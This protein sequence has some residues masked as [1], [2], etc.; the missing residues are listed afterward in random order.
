[1][2]RSL[3]Q[4]KVDLILTDP[5]YGISRKTTFKNMGENGVKRLGVSMDFGQWDHA[6]INLRLFCEKS[7]SA[8]RK[9]G[10]IIVFHDL[11]HSNEGDLIVDPYMGSGTTGIAALRDGQEAMALLGCDATSFASRRGAETP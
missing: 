1:M 3:D 10:S 7:F 4:G 5:P 8:L 6:N 11:K 2:L 9:G